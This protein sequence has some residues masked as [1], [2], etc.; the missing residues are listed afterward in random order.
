MKGGRGVSFPA[1]G[2]RRSAAHQELLAQLLMDE[3]GFVALLQL[4]ATASAPVSL[5]CS[6]MEVLRGWN[7]LSGCSWELPH[8][9]SIS[10]GWV[11][12]QLC[13]P[14]AG[15]WCGTMAQGLRISVSTSEFSS[16][17]CNRSQCCII[18]YYCSHRKN[19]W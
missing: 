11:W 13:A 1:R 3:M 5:H 8:R 14:K 2:A 19:Y 7:N 10:S 6:W 12:E 9:Q 15:A 18:K 4:P 16:T 17:C